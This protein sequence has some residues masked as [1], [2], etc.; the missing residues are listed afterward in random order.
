MLIGYQIRNHGVNG[1]QI[2]VD[3]VKESLRQEI[4]AEFLEMNTG[5]EGKEFLHRELLMGA[6]QNTKA[7][8]REEMATN[9]KAAQK[10]E[11]GK[12]MNERGDFRRDPVSS[13]NIVIAR[14][15]D[16]APREGNMLERG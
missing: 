11:S 5:L 4:I 14:A 8:L 12:N 15:G 1:P 9:I 2:S 7:Y 16:V 13:V 6:G 10:E 3:E